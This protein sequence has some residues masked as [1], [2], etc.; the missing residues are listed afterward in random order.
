MKVTFLRVTLMDYPSRSFKLTGEADFHTIFNK[1]VNEST[2]MLNAN[3]SRLT[4]SQW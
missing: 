2:A 1:T 4:Y 3:V